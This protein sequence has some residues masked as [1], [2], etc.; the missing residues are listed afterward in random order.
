MTSPTPYSCRD[1]HLQFPWRISLLAV[2]AGLCVHLLPGVQAQTTIDWA[3][4]SQSGP[5]LDGS[6]W[7]GGEIPGVDDFFSINAS[8]PITIT[9]GATHSAEGLRAGASA[10]HYTLELGGN[11]LNLIATGT[12]G[13]TRSFSMPNTS[14]ARSITLENG[15]LAAD[16]FDFRGASTE[17]IVNSNAVFSVKGIN[18]QSSTLTVEGTLNTT[19]R[20]V[21]VRSGGTIDINGGTWN[22]ESGEPIYSGEAGLTTESLIHFRN[23][24]SADLGILVAGRDTSFSGG[25][26]DGGWGLILVE[27]GGTTV[28][29]ERLYLSGG[30]GT[31]SGPE[32]PSPEGIGSVHVLDGSIMTADRLFAFERSTIYLDEGRLNV[33]ALGAIIQEGA[34]LRIGL[35]SPAQDVVLSVDTLDITN[36]TFELVLGP[37]FSAN[38][39][40]EFSLV[41]YETSLTGQFAGLAEGAVINV[42]DMYFELSYGSGGAMSH[43]SLMVV[44]E[45]GTIL[46]LLL[47]GAGFLVRHR[48]RR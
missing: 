23:E 29:S 46:F 7:T 42:D 17:V 25:F 27:G 13:T 44:P 43:I 28:S 39:F 24:A 21:Q 16:D 18:A 15:V 31:L 48:I 33:G 30:S 19:D 10:G 3:D 1:N 26:N 5:F 40:D 36:A 9:L 45:P 32:N 34:T 8:Q 47:V 12:S 2:T 38:M 11:T 41:S 37:G 14:N 35:H 20:R 22:G 6:S 4:G